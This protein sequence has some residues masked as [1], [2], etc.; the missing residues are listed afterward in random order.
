MEHFLPADYQLESGLMNRRLELR[1]KSSTQSVI[2]SS[3]GGNSKAMGT[4]S[5]GVFLVSP[6]LWQE[7]GRWPVPDTPKAA[8]ARPQVGTPGWVQ[9]SAL[10]PTVRSCL[11]GSC[12]GRWKLSLA[13]WLPPPRSERPFRRELRCR[14]SEGEEASSGRSGNGPRVRQSVVT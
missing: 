5:C 11:V 14:G 10:C 9:S 8:G 13:S 12:E 1:G 2:K 6:P 4:P 3:A 7:V